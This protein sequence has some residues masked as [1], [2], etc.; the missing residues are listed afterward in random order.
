M[1]ETKKLHRWNAHKSMS[2]EGLVP[3]IH[4]LFL[5]LAHMQ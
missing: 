4:P 2:L 5:S 3:R 1:R